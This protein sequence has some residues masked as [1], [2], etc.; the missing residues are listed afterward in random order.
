MAQRGFL[1]LILYVPVAT[2]IATPLVP[3]EEFTHHAFLDEYGF[4]KLFWKFNQEKITFEVHVKTTGYVGFGFSP[5]GGM[6]G[7][8]IV[9]GWM[10]NNGK[11]QFTDRHALHYGEPRIDIKQ[12]YTLLYGREEDEYT[13]LKFERKLDTCDDE[14][15]RII[16][17]DTMR[18]I[19]AYHPGKPED[20]Q[21]LPWHGREKRGV[22]SMYLM[23]VS[24]DL[25]PSLEGENVKIMEFLNENVS[26][27]W[28][29]DT[30]YNCKGFAIPRLNG[31]H[32]IIKYEPIVQ[33]GNEALVHHILVYMCYGDLND[34]HHGIEGECYSPNMP[35]ELYECGTTIMAWAIGGGP[36]FFPDVAGF[37]LGDDGDPT[38]VMLETHY[39]NPEYKSSSFRG[40][41][42]YEDLLYSK[43]RE[44]DATMLT[45]GHL[46]RPTQVIP[47]GMRKFTTKAY[48]SGNCTRNTLTDSSTNE[49]TDLHI[50]AG[51]LHSHLAGRSMRLRHIREGTE[52]PNI[53]KDEYYDFNYQE[54]NHLPTEVILKAG[55]SLML[56]CD[57]DTMDRTSPIYGGLGTYDEMCLAFMYTY[58]R[59]SLKKCSS[60]L[61]G[62]SIAEVVNVEI[63]R[64]LL[65]SA[66][67]T[68]YTICGN[69]TAKKKILSA[70]TGNKLCKTAEL[71]AA[72]NMMMGTAVSTSNQVPVL[73]VK[74]VHP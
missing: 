67:Q 10:T 66:T 45:V 29:Q 3:T 11:T 26:V 44:F 28:H 53:I 47:P 42:W 34:T 61:L 20:G 74:G 71:S 9:I 35:P 51:N 39:D 65:W 41:F 31:K 69:V 49:T 70:Y 59:S 15:D 19:W 50:F 72:Q 2:I 12:D 4:Y 18:L 17:S 24:P 60:T 21:P 36:F 23:S 25:I 63:D 13:I 64:G 32:H 43:L 54:L 22:R 73:N 1:L 57:Y 14:Q 40:Q 48:C 55:D 33:P 6:P 38:F 62:S 16:T 58:P 37:S 52:L 30:T 27:P 68:T 56:E 8:D 46:V 7:S 5:N